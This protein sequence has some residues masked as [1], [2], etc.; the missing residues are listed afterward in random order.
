M[1]SQPQIYVAGHRG[2][3]VC[4]IVRTLLQHGENDNVHRSH[5]ELDLANRT[6][7][8]TAG[9]FARARPPAS[10]ASWATC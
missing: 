3:V 4:A 9:C 7:I 2:M 8:L 5:A 10:C 1:A 6:M